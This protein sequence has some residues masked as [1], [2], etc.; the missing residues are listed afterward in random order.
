MHGRPLFAASGCAPIAAA[1]HCGPHVLAVLMLSGICGALLGLR[2][3]WQTPIESAQVLAGLVRYPDD[4]PFYAYHIHTWTLLHQ[5]PAV[6]LKL[7]L[8][9]AAVSRLLGGAVGAVAFQSVALASYVFSRR[10]GWSIGLPLLLAACGTLD[11]FR[12]V[13]PLRIAPD[14]PWAAYGICGTAWVLLTWGMLA[15][16]MPRAGSFALGIAPALHPVLGAWGLAVAIG[17]TV[18]LRRRGA[19]P[20]LDWRWLAAALAICGASLAWQRL[21]W[22]DPLYPHLES[23]D[24][25]LR[26]YANAWDTHRQPYPLISLGMAGAL[27]V[28]ALTWQQPFKAGDAGGAS[29]TALGCLLGASTVGAIALC[30]ATH[31]PWEWPSWFVSAMPGRFVNLSLLAL[32]SLVLGRLAC[33]DGSPAADRVLACLA[34]VYGVLHLPYQNSAYLTDPGWALLGAGMYL[35]LYTRSGWGI[36]GNPSS[37]STDANRPRLWSHQQAW[38]FLVGGAL[39]SAIVF[40]DARAGLLVASLWGLG[41]GLQRSSARLRRAAVALAEGTALCAFAV[42]AYRLYGLPATASLAVLGAGVRGW[43]ISRQRQDATASRRHEHGSA[44]AWRPLWLSCTWRAASGIGAVGWLASAAA[45]L[46]QP[47]DDWQHD[48]F[49]RAV[50]QGEG[51]IV[52]VAGVGSVQMRSRRPVLLEVSALNQLPYVPHSAPAMNQILKAV[53]GVDLLRGPPD[54]RRRPGIAPEAPRELWERR[55]VDE[56]QELG[57]RF[58]FT[59]VLAYRDWQLQLP[60]VA[61]SEKLVLFRVPRTGPPEHGTAMAHRNSGTR[62]R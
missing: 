1:M 17:T 20:V 49:F 12:G 6:L 13:Y 9:E 58:G 52:T 11:G 57:A 28:A 35:V 7:G 55:S 39:L 5:V 31:S 51:M 54:G 30:L 27:L 29:I 24:E 33:R 16:G 44:E 21:G 32:P 40:I 38:R 19:V 8:S 53:Y 36:G 47:L 45:A 22:P 61:E 4:N 62:S 2:A 46:G 15:A 42:A 41:A 23:G 25:Y 3:G 43:L 60:R 50:H 14:R 18:Y 56:W 34:V 48:A 37:A 59:D 26:A 10:A